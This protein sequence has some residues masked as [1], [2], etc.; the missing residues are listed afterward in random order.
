MSFKEVMALRRED[1]LSE[2]LEMAKQDLAL[3]R[4]SY[5]CSALF[6]VLKDIAD[7]KIAANE[8]S[9]LPDIV[10]RMESLVRDMEDEQGFAAQSLAFIKKR[11]L[12][13]EDLDVIL[14]QEIQEDVAESV[15]WR[16]YRRLKDIYLAAGL[17]K[18]RH[19]IERFD[20]L[21]IDRPSV[22]NTAFLRLVAKVASEYPELSMASYLRAWNTDNFMDE[23][24]YPQTV[25]GKTYRSALGAVLGVCFAQGTS[26]GEVSGIFRNN[27]S[28]TDRMLASEYSNYFSYRLYLASD[29]PDQEYFSIVRDYLDGYDLR[30]QADIRHSSIL[31]SVIFRIDG[32]RENLWRFHDIFDA[33]GPLSFME[34]DWMA[35][36]DDRGNRYRSLVEK[37]IFLYQDSVEAGRNSLYGEEFLELLDSACLRFPDNPYLLRIKASAMAAGGN[38]K[39]ALSICREVLK[40]KQDYYMWAEL[41]E[42]AEDSSLKK[43]ALCK[44]LSSGTKDE[45][46]GKIRLQL[47]ALMI[48]DGEYPEALHELDRYFRTYSSSGWKLSQ[49]YAGLKDSVPEGIVPASDNASYYAS[50]RQDAEDFVVSDVPAKEMIVVDEYVNSRTHRPVAELS[51]RD[52]NEIRL[53]PRRFRLPEKGNVGKVF[54]VRLLQVGTVIKPVSVSPQPVREPSELQPVT[55]SGTVK[56]KVNP[57]GRKFAFI[58]DIY[59]PESKLAG[60]SDGDAIEVTAVKISS[61]YFILSVTRLA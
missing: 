46:V 18:C 11:L 30:R 42:Y 47:A 43:S 50:H 57:K 31:N 33:W 37:A 39:S 55:A 41:A 9:G 4:D 58:Q 60:I 32:S 6:W 53:D 59:V 21:P 28:V 38:L 20:S 2:A 36:T 29:K 56:M 25:K 27:T 23:D 61:R 8:M 3:K 15:G 16:V 17:D 49:D 34:E 7:G 1:R 19:Y 13:S 54:S 12:E 5:S 44:A 51:D 14:G 26:L 52:G 40:L 24:L 45:F 22:L 35:E 10:S 48:A